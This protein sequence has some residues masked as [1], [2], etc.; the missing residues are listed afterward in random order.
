M[1]SSAAMRGAAPPGLLSRRPPPA[2]WLPE[3]IIGA[4]V[5]AYNL[6]LL[7]EHSTHPLRFGVLVAVSAI[8]CFAL[9]A[10][11]TR[12]VGVAVT[13][14]VAAIV[15]LLCGAPLIVADVM[16][17]AA[18]YTV[19]ALRQ[20]VVSATV[21]CAAV[22]W[23]LAAVIPNLDE[24][25]VDIGELGVV[26]VVVGWVWT[27]GLLARLRRDRLTALRDRAEQAEREQR[28]LADA[29]VAQER[30]R[31]AREIHDVV[32]HG[33]GVVVVL[34]EGAAAAVESD[35]QRARQAMLSVRDTGRSGLVEMRRMLGILRDDRDDRGGHDDVAPSSRITQLAA[36][37]ETERSAGLPV[38]LQ[39]E[40]DSS[41]STAD[42]GLTVYRVVQE[43]LTNVRRHAGPD[44]GRVDVIVRFGADDVTIRV[45]DDGTGTRGSRTDDGTGFGLIGIR[46]RVD[47]HGGRLYVGDRDVG[48]YEL[49][50]VF[51]TAAFPTAESTPAEF[52]PS[53]FP[54]VSGTVGASITPPERMR[55]R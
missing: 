50:A 33:L 5:F 29:A 32:S 2:S 23:L 12:P 7:M 22:A 11:R 36:L 20:T 1:N 19:A 37:V 51:P 47:A 49:T 18:V 41:S 48:G 55:D 31:M 45:T 25:F 53:E 34:S 46:E 3:I 8:L 39:V 24:D 30:T 43:A 9:V 14:L 6:P 26:L 4:A 13:M 17:L 10:R 16:L 21:A 52:P 27:W 28:A 42:V 35:P 44:V 15:Q 38:R 40:G 54:T